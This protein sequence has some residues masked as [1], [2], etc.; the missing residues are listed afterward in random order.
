LAMK[1]RRKTGK[2]RPGMNGP[3]L[4]RFAAQAPTPKRHY[5]FSGK[6]MLQQ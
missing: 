6:I 5:R 1:S 3:L 4:Y 2:R